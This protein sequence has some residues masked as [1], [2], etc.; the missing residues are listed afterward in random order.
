MPNASSFAVTLVVLLLID[1]DDGTTLV[2]PGLI[3]GTCSLSLPIISSHPCLFSDAIVAV[4]N[5]AD[6]DDDAHGHDR[7][8]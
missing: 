5:R 2:R 6:E 3:S 8:R 1:H 4:I 7:C